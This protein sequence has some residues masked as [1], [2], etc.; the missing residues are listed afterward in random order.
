MTRVE[1]ER[2]ELDVSGTITFHNTAVIQALKKCG[3]NV[4]ISVFL[5]K[6]IDE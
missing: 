5:P 2:L 3:N 4:K 1:K 6:D